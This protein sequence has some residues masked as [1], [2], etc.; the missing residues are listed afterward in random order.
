V[1]EYVR[2]EGRRVV[3]FD[4][5][6]SGPPLICIPGGPGYGGMQLAR[7]GGLSA[8]RTLHR[9]DLRGAGESDPPDQESYGFA[10]YAADLEVLRQHLGLERMDLMGHAHG[11]LSVAMYARLF[12]QHVGSIVL[13]GVPVRP[14]AEFDDGTET[15]VPDYFE[16]YDSR[17]AHYVSEHMGRIH[18]PAMAWFWDHEAGVDFRTL[19]AGVTAPTLL[20]TG[21]D[22]PMA[23]PRA[24]ESLADVMADASV[25]VIPR[26]SHFAW[27]ENP[28]A[29]TEKV[30]HFLHQHVHA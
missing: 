16:T 29:Y 24:V 5:I 7:L 11:G 19:V 14:V 4:T 2:V 18:E 10:D 12:P 13:D 9:L 17:A 15:G 1:K 30:E 3:A 6:G 21:I 26:A 22:D 23:G 20:L 28:G 25:A 27:V 8:T